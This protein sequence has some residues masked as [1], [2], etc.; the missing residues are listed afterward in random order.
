MKAIGRSSSDVAFPLAL[1][2]REAA[3]AL[4]ICERLLWQKTKDGEIPHVRVGRAVVYP[5][6]LLE[7]WLMAQAKR[8]DA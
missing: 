5:V 1:R 2:P 8:S 3:Q 6:S 4:G 7:A